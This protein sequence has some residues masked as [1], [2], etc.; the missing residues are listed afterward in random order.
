MGVHDGHR[1][2]MRQRYLKNGVDNLAEHEVLELLL[3]Y[4]IPR[5]DTNEEAHALMERYDSLS[6]VLS[7]PI[8]DLQKV[9]GIGENAAILL[10]LV[11][12]I[13]QKARLMDVERETILNSAERVGAYVLELFATERNEVVYQL[14]L[15]R[16]G[17]LL[18]R[19]CIG[20]GN[21][22]SV[23]LD[24]RQV[25]ENV[26]LT[27]ASGVILTHNHPSGL[28]LPSQEDVSATLRIKEALET[29]QVTLVDHMIVADGDCVSME[30]S[31]Y[32]L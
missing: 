16:K 9:K 23:D 7:A 3:Y 25:V 24:I 11:P 21:M 14:C 19:K 2:R 13:C 31:G 12:R 10:H 15:D 6:G 17:K 30:Q 4:A 26:I 20:Q 8:E 1:E 27:G 29:I 28:A 18:S 32:L 5:R 22:S